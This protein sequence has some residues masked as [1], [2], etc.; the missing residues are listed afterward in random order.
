[1]MPIDVVA[2]V[3]AWLNGAGLEMA[4]QKTEAML[5]GNRKKV[6]SMRVRVGNHTTA[7]SLVLK[8]LGV[9]I[10]KRLGFTIHT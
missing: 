10:D 5:I 9:M 4:E 1:M 3:E 8:H 2:R 6:E 7:S